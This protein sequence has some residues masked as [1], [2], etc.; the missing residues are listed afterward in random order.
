MKSILAI[1]ATTLGLGLLAPN[2]NA[3]LITGVTASTNMGAGP[4]SNIA[5]TV[6]GVGL[7]RACHQL[8]QITVAAR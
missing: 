5:N 1:A 4:F 7:P 2:A 3:A 6:N 8:S